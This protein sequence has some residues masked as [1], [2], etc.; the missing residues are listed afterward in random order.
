[1]TGPW[2][3]PEVFSS[4]T[5]SCCHPGKARSAGAAAPRAS[6][7]SVHTYIYM[8]FPDIDVQTRRLVRSG[9][10]LDATRRSRD[11]P[12]PKKRMLGHRRQAS[13]RRSTPRRRQE[14][15]LATPRIFIWVGAREATK[16][17]EHH[18]F[19][20]YKK[21]RESEKKTKNIDI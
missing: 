11:A 7:H 17:N 18:F 13:S 12:T 2:G 10:E 6:A 21:R 8:D 19:E 3:L 5:A 16:R 15:S 4:P 1:M 20:R 14:R 9:R